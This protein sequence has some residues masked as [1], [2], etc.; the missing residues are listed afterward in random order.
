LLLAFFIKN[1]V[2]SRDFYRLPSF[3]ALCWK[4]MITS[5]LKHLL[6]YWYALEFF[7]PNWPVKEKEDVDLQTRA[8]PWP[9][10]QPESAKQN[11]YDIY[12]GCV[13]AFELISWCLN[14]LALPVEDSPVE[15]DLSKCCLCALKVDEKGVYVAGSF[16][17]S[18]FV[19]ALGI[20]ARSHDFNA[21]LSPDDLESFRSWVDIELS[22]KEEPFSLE[23]LRSFFTRICNESGLEPGVLSPS[24]WARKN[25]QRLKEGES[26]EPS[27]ELIPSYYVREIARVR[28]NPGKQ[29]ER[30]AGALYREPG[31]R[32]AI[33]TDVASMKQ[34][35]KSDRFPRGAWPSVFSPSLMQ[36]LAINLAISNQDIFS[37]NGPPGTG[38]T[39][40]LKEIVASAIVGRAALMAGYNTPDD[41][42]HMEKFNNPPDRYNQTFYRPDGALTAFGILVASNNNAAVENISLELP[43]AVGKDRSGHFTEIRN[44]DEAYFSD[45]ASALLGEPAWGL[46]SARLGKKQNLKK[47]K[48]RLWWDKDGNTLRSY[49]AQSPPDEKSARENFLT[50]KENFRIAWEAVE[51]ERKAIADIQETVEQYSQAA[52]SER[53]IF[54]ECRRL[55][56]ESDEQSRVF[57]E[58]QA[59]LEGTEKVY[60][61]HQQNALMLQS[62]LSYFKRLFPGRFKKDPV[63]LEWKRVK[64]Q[65]DETL[66]ALTRQRTELQSQAEKLEAVNQR[67]RQQKDFLRGIQE[68]KRLLE[69]K[70]AT[71]KKRFGENYADDEFWRDISKNEKSQSA[72]PWTDNAYDALREELF[73]RALM[74]QKAFVLGSNCVRQNLARLFGMWDGVFRREDREM[75]YG[76]LLNTLFFVIPVIS[77][78]FASVQSFLEGIQPDELGIL[79]VD[80]SGQAT[81]QSALGALWRT[82][83]AIVVGDPLQVEP[84]LTTPTELRKRFADSCNLPAEYRIP[85]LSVQILADAQ[86]PYGGRQE[87]DDGQML[88]LGCPLVIHRRCVEPMFSMSNHVAY[89]GRMFC[90]TAKP[91]ES[92]GFLLESS[93]WFDIPGAERGRKDH[94]VP[95]QI[96]L[97]ARLMEKAIAQFGGFPNLYII[98]PFTSVKRSLAKELRPLLRKLLPGTDAGAVDNWIDEHCGTIHTFQGKEANEVLLVLGCDGGQGLN[99]ARWVGQKPN[100][101]NVAVSRAKYRIGVL[102]NYDLWKEIPYVKTVSGMLSVEKK[103]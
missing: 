65:C 41:A 43:K 9:Q 52:E 4:G 1:V 94:T 17:V 100:I 57:K 59:L 11:F 81:P 77:T 91:S 69:D 15:R 84:I 93:I 40:L 20:M 79:V 85:E 5:V 47:L 66:I 35:L 61:S 38:K 74:L 31:K 34:W 68:Q 83:K 45:I 63:V 3:D 64:V 28:T 62:G 55:Q 48:D 103:A 49:Y 78:T 89:S 95:E 12:F 22:A 46:V 97:A 50:A 26:P 21:K 102:G 72:C 44:T 98:T 76:S 51:K 88:W 37:V 101:I 2:E 56:E 19:W 80:E 10:E 73:Y 58:Q 14:S 39:T 36:Q 70:L 82:R 54:A 27:T 33:D 23:A 6:D 86:N 87:M 75:A 60:S 42:F 99:A 8:L 71:T 29:I 92:E 25:P 67:F 90:K 24:L 32:I 96:D 18:A 13:T 30:Y 16:A 7:Q 53:V